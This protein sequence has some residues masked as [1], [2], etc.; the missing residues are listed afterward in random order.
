MLL[1]WPILAPL[2][3]LCNTWV[4]SGPVHRAEPPLARAC[5]VGAVSN[6]DTSVRNACKRGSRLGGPLS[7]CP[8]MRALYCSVL[9]NACPPADRT[10]RQTPPSRAPKGRGAWPGLAA[11]AGA[12]CHTPW[13]HSKVS[14]FGGRGSLFFF[15]N[16]TSSSMSVTTARDTQNHSVDGARSH[17][18]PFWQHVAISRPCSPFTMCLTIHPIC[19][20]SHRLPGGVFKTDGT[21]DAALYCSP[22]A[23]SLHHK[24]PPLS[25]RVQCTQPDVSRQ[26]ESGMSTQSGYAG[27]VR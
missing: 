23:A 13:K 9:C 20:V 3:L 10:H 16:E 22:L 24:R 4:V 11:L 2:E 27:A 21:S 14:R 25:P 12:L 17:R 7:H 5:L 18:P 8:R 1:S 26:A 15:S 19:F 6:F